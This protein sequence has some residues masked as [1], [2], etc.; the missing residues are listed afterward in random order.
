MRTNTKKFQQF[1]FE[2]DLVKMLRE[3]LSVSERQPATADEICVTL[4]P[5]V[6][7]DVE[8]SIYWQVLAAQY[9]EIVINKENRWLPKLQETWSK[10]KDY[11]VP[12][13]ATYPTVLG[14]V[15]PSVARENWC[16]ELATY[17]R[18][19]FTTENVPSA[20]GQKTN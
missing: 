2:R 12:Q 17:I 3:N 1:N 20:V 8:V 11:P 14:R 4:E 13:S 15:V 19:L 18:R 16:T 5:H 10:V 7:S 9:S 6:L